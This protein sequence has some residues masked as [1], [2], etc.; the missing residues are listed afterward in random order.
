MIVFSPDYVGEYVISFIKLSDAWLIFV[1]SLAIFGD[2]E[3]SRLLYETW[4]TVY[5]QALIRRYVL[6]CQ[7]PLQENESDCGL[8]LLH[9]I[10]KF[11][12]NAPKAMK[13][14]DLEGN[15]D[16]LGVVNFLSR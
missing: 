6:S 15:W 1:L 7:V 10:R 16:I 4:F 5:A 9:Y 2:L 11:V 13:L 3:A 12:E 14:C 8:F